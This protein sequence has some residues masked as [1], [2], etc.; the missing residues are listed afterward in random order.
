[1]LF[2][3]LCMLVF[4]VIVQIYC[5]L[6]LFVLLFIQIVSLLLK[7]GVD[8]NLR[9]FRGEVSNFFF[10]ICCFRSETLEQL[11]SKSKNNRFF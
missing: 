4:A 10:I 3:N 11:S 9:N 6:I 7:S 1:M 8:I 5:S 2:V